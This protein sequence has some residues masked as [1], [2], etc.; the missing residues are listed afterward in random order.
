MNNMLKY[1]GNTIIWLCVIILFA[2]K[3]GA[4]HDFS[5]RTVSNTCIIFTAAVFLFYI[6][7]ALINPDTKSV[8][9]LPVLA[10]TLFASL[11]I[12][13][14]SEVFKIKKLASPI[15]Y[16]LN[17]VL[18]ITSCLFIYIAVLGMGETAGQKFVFVICFSLVWGAC[19]LIRIGIASIKAKINE[20]D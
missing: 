2:A 7:A 10:A 15:K 1:L 14:C 4:M 13:L 12:S 5:K 8:M 19:M 11:L 17:F 3:G 6:F 18:S 16:I 20:K 9:T